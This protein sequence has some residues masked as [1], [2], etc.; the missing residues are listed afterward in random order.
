M[1]PKGIRVNI[2][3]P[4]EQ[5]RVLTKHDR[6]FIQDVATST[7]PGKSHFITFVRLK[8]FEMEGRW[9]L[10]QFQA[11]TTSKEEAV[12]SGYSENW[13]NVTLLRVISDSNEWQPPMGTTRCI[14]F[15]PGA[16][17]C[18]VWLKVPAADLDITITTPHQSTPATKS[19]HQL[20]YITPWEFWKGTWANTHST[21]R[22]CSPT[23]RWSLALL[24]LTIGIIVVIVASP[25][26]AVTW[27]QYA[28]QFP[29]GWTAYLVSLVV[30]ISTTITAWAKNTWSAIQST[31]L[32]ILPLTNWVLGAVTF[33][34]ISWA[35]YSW[36]STQS[37]SGWATSLA[38]QPTSATKPK[39]NTYITPWEA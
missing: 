20:D 9:V 30:S 7:T 29:S 38:K 23:A 31:M 36:S 35:K 10:G 11:P 25:Y 26:L 12:T 6:T 4:Q 14:N 17:W 1:T 5:T 37:L 39:Q 22:D 8:E 13:Y 27:V 15:Q 19:P 16:P 3:T 32:Q 21:Y 34:I 24:T 2:T 33:S 28:S 18:I